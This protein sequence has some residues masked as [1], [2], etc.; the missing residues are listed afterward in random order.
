MKRS[1]DL[2]QTARVALRAG[3]RHQTL[4]F[5]GALAFL[6]FIVFATLPNHPL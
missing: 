2:F 5:Y 1:P 6:A 4:A 3:T